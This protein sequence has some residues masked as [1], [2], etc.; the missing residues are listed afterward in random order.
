MIAV[1]GFFTIDPVFRLGAG[2]EPLRL[3]RD[4]MR[5]W[6]VGAPTMPAR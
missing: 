5:I 6:Y 1:A 2:G 3:V 4:F